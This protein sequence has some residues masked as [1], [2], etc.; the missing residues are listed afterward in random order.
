MSRNGGDIAS[1]SV[2]L[3]WCTST[4]Y[5]LHQKTQRIPL[6]PS[7][8]IGE[9]FSLTHNSEICR[10]TFLRLV[11]IIIEKVEGP[12]R[13]Q[14]SECCSLLE[15][16]LTLLKGALE[17]PFSSP[18]AELPLVACLYSPWGLFFKITKLY[19]TYLNLILKNGQNKERKHDR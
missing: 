18:S 12:I 13:F 8:T 10:L 6:Y 1:T 9:Q 17:S 15:G 11:W 7:L 2:A 5:G 3:C 14:Y 16:L 19:I 4:P